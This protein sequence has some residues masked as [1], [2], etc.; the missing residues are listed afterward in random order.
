MPAPREVSYLGYLFICEPMVLD[1]GRFGAQILI[2]SN[3][4]I[5]ITENRFPSLEDFSNE[6]DA[7]EYAKRWGKAWVDLAAVALDN[8]R[9]RG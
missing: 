8:D 3:N 1:D 4:G 2:R 7:I 5:L 6:H 9:T